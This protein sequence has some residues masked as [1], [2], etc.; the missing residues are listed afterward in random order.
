MKLED[1]KYI[2]GVDDIINNS[3]FDEIDLKE[4]YGDKLEYN[5]KNLS[6]KTYRVMYGAYRGIHRERQRAWLD[7]YIQQNEKRKYAMRDAIIEYIRGSMVTGMDLEDYIPSASVEE[8]LKNKT[9]YPPMV[10][11]ILRENGL[12]VTSTVVYRDEELQ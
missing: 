8:R 12:W 6:Q 7:W 10:E 11:N 2:I 5:L 3:E 4:T 9:I 1:N